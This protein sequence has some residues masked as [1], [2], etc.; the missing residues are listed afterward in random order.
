MTKIK[1]KIVLID[2]EKCDGCGLCV[3]ACHEGA[4]QIADGKAR[5]V[6][7]RLC[8]GL[9]DCLGRCPQHAITIV[10]R[11]AEEFD[12]GAV[13]LHL[14]QLTEDQ[15]LPGGC[16]GA[17]ATSIKKP[18]NQSAASCQPSELSQWPVQLHLVPVDAP[19]FH[20]ADL[21]LCADC[22]PLALGAF[23]SRLLKGRAVAIACPKLDNTDNYG[24]KLARIIGENGVRSV[25]VA[26]MEVPCCSGL[27]FLARQAL[28]RSGA[29]VEL[30]EIVISIA[31]E[32]K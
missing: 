12:A 13:R 9:G 29:P 14:Q 32:V 28:D 30:K 7:D 27:T 20:G 6:E 2:E 19:Y 22:V 17:R 26:R 21:L 23:H 11:E 4:I 31:G 25:T 18:Q 15:I 5:L 16:P 8:D 24:D 1:R 10:E 3:P